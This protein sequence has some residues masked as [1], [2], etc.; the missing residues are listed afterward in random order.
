MLSRS[1]V[2]AAA[3]PRRAL[4][5]LAG[6]KF[7]RGEGDPSSRRV[8][9]ALAEKGGIESFGVEEVMVDLGAMENRSDEF[10]RKTGSQ[11][12]PVLE[13]ADGEFLTQSMAI[14]K[15]IDAL[16]PNEPSLFGSTPIQQARIEMAIRKLEAGL[17]AALFGAFQH[18][19]EFFAPRIT[20]IPEWGQHCASQLPA[21]MDELELELSDGKAYFAGDNFSAADI[22][23]I[24]ALD[25]GKVLK[26]RPDPAAHPNLMAWLERMKAR[27]SYSA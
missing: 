4:S 19:S 16:G 25:F 20:Q 15:L 22:A 6:A 12:V 23:V 8:R 17:P 3:L 18:T 27:P 2:L 14:M 13:L 10:K 7:Y 11:Q 5:T 21:K 9:I 1:K 26:C 24:V